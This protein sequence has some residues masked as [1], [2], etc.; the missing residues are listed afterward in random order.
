[1]IATPETSLASAVVVAGG[2]LDL[3]A[4]LV[5]ARADVLGL[6]AA[7]DDRGLVLG[8]DDLLGGAELLEL[9]ILEAAADVLGEEGPAGDD[10]DVAEHRL[11]TVA[12][13]GR[14]DGADLE[15]AAQA[16]DDER[17]ERLVLDLFRDD[18][19]RL[20]GRRDLVEDRQQLGKVRDLLLVDE[21]E[22][23]L[24]HALGALRI[25]HEVGREEAL[26]ERH[27]LDIV[28]R[29][30][31]GLAFLDLADAI[32]ADL[33]DRL[34]DELADRGVVVGGHGRDLL[35]VGLALALLRHLG[36]GVGGC[37]GRGVDAALDR[38]GVRARGDVLQAAV[39]DRA[40]EDG[41]AGGAVARDVRG[42][43]RDLL[44]HLGAHVLERSGEIDLLRDG[45]AVLGDVRAAVAL[46]EEHVVTDG[47]HR[48]G[49]G[50]HELVDAALE[51][52]A[53][54]RIELHLLLCHVF[55][56]FACVGAWIT[57]P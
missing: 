48:H 10:A 31:G 7:L 14:L 43:L 15:H 41:G 45:D 16:V 55:A 18:D 24:E 40:G 9:D 2:A 6:A 1:M 39:E 22:R 17:G 27:A 50:L 52:R 23:V 51:F 49:H 36:D 25:G 11:A 13:A 34:G 3:R 44:H 8:D 21:D 19:E 56:F 42:L 29:R 5:G 54:R 4:E 12:E 35:E 20:A 46:R 47:T 30:L 26:V 33:V 28:E 57:W 53:R 32:G 38:D 37:L